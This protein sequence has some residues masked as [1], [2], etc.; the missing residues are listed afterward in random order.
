MLVWDTFRIDP[1]YRERLREARLDS[2]GRA[3]DR[4]DGLVA[5][6]SRST[7]TLYVAGR[8]SDPGL[9][10]KRVYMPR[11]SKRWRGALRGT[12][13]GL[14]RGHAEY[15]ALNELRWA[16]IPA[17]R[18]VA[19]GSRM[20]AGFVAATIL[21]T[22]AAPDAVN[23][24]TFAQQLAA[25]ER[26]LTR[27]QRR[28]MLA[29][30]AGLVA[31]MH[32]AG[33]SHGNLYWRNILVRPAPQSGCEFFLLDAQPLR[34]W[35]KL[36]SA[37]RWWLGELAQLYASALPFTT[38]AERLRFARLYFGAPRLTAAVKS[39]LREIVRL[40]EAGRAHED[41]RVWLNL[42]FD[43]WRGRWL[44]ETALPGGPDLGADS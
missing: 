22:E 39:R 12:L 25:G 15:L 14:H 18:P 19:Y 16:G 20:V 31:D 35:E 11:W 1:A 3:L 34:L 43:R 4:V 32:A 28:E 36:G 8:G 40:A 6:W 7:E 42:L 17:V 41:R 23:L 13:L 27:T 5:A 44:R 26:T 29:T 21:I 38:R 33:V 30:L 9:F 24:T 10:L 37:G 2:V